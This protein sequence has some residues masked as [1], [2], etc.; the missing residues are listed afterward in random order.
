MTNLAHSFRPSLLILAI[1]GIAIA[2]RIA[3]ILPDSLHHPDEIGQYLEQAHRIVFGYGTVTWENRLGMRHGLL[4][5]L[6]SAPMALGKLIAPNSEL[7]L[8]LPRLTNGALSLAIL[9][10]AYRIGRQYSQPHAMIA[11]VVAAFWYEFVMLAAHTLSEPLATAAILVA[12]A[13]LYDQNV[14]KSGLLAA[15]FLFGIG[16][17]L[18]FHYALPAAIIAIGLC[19]PNWKSKLFPVIMG[20]I[21]AVAIGALVDLSMGMV[22]YQWVFNNIYQNVVLN[23]SANYGTSPPNAYLTSFWFQ[24]GPSAIV[25]LP[26]L[27]IGYK[28]HRPLIWAAI[29]NLA[30][31]S[32]IGHKEYRFVFLSTAI[33]LLIAALASVDVLKWL[34][35]RRG[36][37]LSSARLGILGLVWVSLSGVQAL[38]PDIKPRWTAFSEFKDVMAFAKNDPEV[39]GIAIEAKAFWLLGSYSKLN[40]NIPLYVVNPDYS[41]PKGWAAERSSEKAFNVVIGT[42]ALTRVFSAD[43]ASMRCIPVQTTAKPSY[44]PAGSTKVCAFRRTGGCDPN[45]GTHREINNWLIRTGH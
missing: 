19:W 30:V 45:A 41:K 16:I 2:L 25:I 18:R 3:A 12:A 28:R 36:L 4:P 32:A 17:L 43:Y 14:K 40:R 24:W 13:L 21:I 29:A 5:V 44:F 39:C 23:R 8:L 7:Y 38:S 10:A 33:L 42:D 1:V 27:V 26:L 37:P 34:S 6:L 22:P 31:H 35:A 11:L 15:G 9:W 20:G